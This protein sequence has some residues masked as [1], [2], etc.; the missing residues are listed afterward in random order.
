MKRRVDYL[1][2]VTDDVVVYMTMIMSLWGIVTMGT[3][4]AVTMQPPVAAAVAYAAEVT[5]STLT[6]SLRIPLI[7]M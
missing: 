2:T 7:F 5:A 4:A 1:I 3:C 6:L